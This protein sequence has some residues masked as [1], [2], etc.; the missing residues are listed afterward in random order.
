MT[1]TPNPTSD[2]FQKKTSKFELTVTP[3]IVE[4]VDVTLAGVVQLNPQEDG[5]RNLECHSL[6]MRFFWQLSREVT[7]VSA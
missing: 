4:E 6:E 3:N 7:Q 5:G 1:P 2:F